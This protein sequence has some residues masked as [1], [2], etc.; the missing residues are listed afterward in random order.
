MDCL[1]YIQK[2]IVGHFRLDTEEVTVLQIA[3]M[4]VKMCYLN[5]C[6]NFFGFL[7]F[8]MH[9]HEINSVLNHALHIFV[10]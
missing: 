6:K 7:D 10:F 9:H 2:D 1:R 8:S 3:D 5:K 4:C